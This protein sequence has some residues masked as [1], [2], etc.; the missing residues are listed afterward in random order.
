VLFR[1]MF[2]PAKSP[3]SAKGT[4]SFVALEQSR[5]PCKAL[6]SIQF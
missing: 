6:L 1:T 3:L 4:R 2:V 5:I